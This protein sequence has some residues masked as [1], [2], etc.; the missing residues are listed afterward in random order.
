MKTFLARLNALILLCMFV[1]TVLTV[2]FRSVLGIPA[3]WSEDLAQLTFILLV[4]VG[5][6]SVMEDEGHIAIS[7][8]FDRFGDRG[9]RIIR[10][11]GRLLILPFLVLFVRG[12]WD[13]MMFNWEVEL[14][15]VEWIRIGHIYLALVVSGAIMIYYTLVNIVRDVRGT[16]QCSERSNSSV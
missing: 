5:A 16:Y 7:T 9:Q 1:V 13:N 10:V 8:I 14:G 3:S 6:A 15:T 12:A 11:L 2:V 4:F